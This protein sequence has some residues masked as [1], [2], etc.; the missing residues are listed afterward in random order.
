MDVLRRITR[1]EWAVSGSK[2]DAK[3]TGNVTVYYSNGTRDEFAGIARGD[4]F[5]WEQKGF[6]YRR[7]PQGIQTKPPIV[8]RQQE[9]KQDEI[10]AQIAADE[11]RYARR[12][13]M[14]KMANEALR[15]QIGEAEYQRL[16]GNW[17][18][19]IG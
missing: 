4:F 19:A 9:D 10:D 5:E 8:D 14:F 12:Q 2:T 1:A 11:S 16:Y 6:D 13:R 7:A 17:F 3:G 15:A 18:G